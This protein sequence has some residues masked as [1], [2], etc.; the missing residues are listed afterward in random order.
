M[1]VSARERSAWGAHA[2]RV[3]GLAY[4]GEPP[5][6]TRESRVLRLAGRTIALKASTKLPVQKTFSLA[7]SERFVVAWLH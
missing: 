5:K 7:A 4:F 1:P 6:R 2:A 3:P